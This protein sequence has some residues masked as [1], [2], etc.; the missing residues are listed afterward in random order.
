MGY[1]CWNSSTK[2]VSGMTYV[3]LSS[4]AC[5]CLWQLSHFCSWWKQSVRISKQYVSK[6]I[7]NS[8][9]NLYTF[10][11]MVNFFQNKEFLEPRSLYK[12]SLYPRVTKS[13]ASA[14]YSRLTR[15]IEASINPSLRFSFISPII[16]KSENTNKQTLDVTSTINVLKWTGHYYTR[17][18]F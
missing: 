11:L 15:W 6:Q 13:A 14:S 9:F 8:K 18:S 3:W 16:P 1:K 4:H 17:F 2:K 7:S 5:K 10:L 12:S